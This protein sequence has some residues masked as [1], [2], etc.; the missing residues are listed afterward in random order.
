LPSRRWLHLTLL[1]RWRLYL[2]LLRWRWLHLTLLRRWRW[3]QLALLRRRWLYLTLLRRRWR[4]A[5]A[6]LRFFLL[7]LITLGCLRNYKG[8][9]QRCCVD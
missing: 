8:G 3:L 7:P 9:F 1:R 6:L 5:W 4:L 2:T